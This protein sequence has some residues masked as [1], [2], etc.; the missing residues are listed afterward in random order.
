MMVNRIAGL[1]TIMVMSSFFVMAQGKKDAS[2]QWETE[3]D[4]LASHQDFEGAIKLY[5]KI[6][7]KSKLKTDADFSVLHKRAFAYYGAGRFSEALQ[8]AN[9]YLK[10]FQDDQQTKLLRLY[11]YQE[12]G[13]TEEQLA[14]L[15]EFLEQ[16]PG[17][18]DL[19]RWRASVLMESERYKEAQQDLRT[20][21]G[22]HADPGL[23]AYLG[24]G[25]YY[26]HDLDSALI[27][28]DEII[29]SDPA[30]IES[31]LYAGSVC[32]EEEAYD[33]SLQYLNKGLAQDPTNATL[34]FYKGIA[35]A[36]KDDTLEGCRCLSKAF[37]AG[38][39]DAA[40][41]LKEYC[42]GVE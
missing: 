22:Y 10:K 33:L 14:G 28:F 30:F 36:E 11:I 3:A 8:D 37:H 4:T 5:T 13:N 12:L 29:T 21:L 6:I 23:K 7:T 1:I 26:Q 24:L 39:D 18:P 35:L 19:L 38:M 41:Y 42:Y 32:L 25:Y 31:Y 15:N 40:D 34:M 2:L 16:S 27:I 17:N 9:Q 20:L